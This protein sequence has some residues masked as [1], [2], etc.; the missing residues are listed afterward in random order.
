MNKISGKIIVKESGIGIPNLLIVF[1][2]YDPKSQPGDIITS[3][4][5]DANFWSGIKGDRIGSV[6]TDKTGSFTL[7]FEDDVFLEKNA[8]DSD[9]RPDL[10]LFVL[11]PEDTL[12]E[13]ADIPY[14][15]SPKKQ[16]L[17]YSHVMRANAGRTENYIIRLRTKQ[18][19]NAEIP[20]PAAPTPGVADSTNI[21]N[22]LEES[23]KLQNQIS[24][25]LASHARKKAK[26]VN[27][28]EKAAQ[29]AFQNFYPSAIPKTVRADTS[30]LAPGKNLR[31]AQR[32]LIQR[33]LNAWKKPASK[34]SIQFIL[35]KGEV[36][37][38]GLA[39]HDDGTV[40]G[41]VGADEVVG[42]VEDS[43]DGAEISAPESPF[44][45]CRNEIEADKKIDAIT[46]DKNGTTEV[47]DRTDGDGVDS[48]GLTAEKLTRDMVALHMDRA[49]SAETQVRFEKPQDPS[50]KD[51]SETVGKIEFGGGATDVT[52][53]HDFYNLQ[54]A[55]EHV[56]T[57]IF[58]GN[59][60]AAGRVLY[61]QW[62]Q[63]KNVA[64]GMGIA[65]DEDITDVETLD[66]LKALMSSV[67]ALN[68]QLDETVEIPP[69]IKKLLPTLTPEIW[70]Q[71]EPSDQ[72]TL[73]DFAA[74]AYLS[75][76][77]AEDVPGLD[78][79][80][81]PR[82]LEDEE[83]EKRIT[84]NRL[85]ALELL[86][87]ATRKKITKDKKPIGLQQ[88][89][90]ELN[91]RLKS[92]YRFDIFAPDSVNLGVLVTYRQEW[93]PGKFQ[94]G[95]LVSTIPLAP[96]EVRKYSKK[97]VTKRSRKE[98]EIENALNIRKGE[99][100]NT[101][102]IEGEIVRKAN[103]KTNFKASAEGSINFGVGSAQASTGLEIDQEK[104]SAQTKKDFREAVTKAAQE[105]KQENKLEIESSSA[106]EFEET[107]S[108][109]ISNPNDEIPVTYLFYELQRQ[110]QIS[111]KLH[112]LTPV[113]LVANHVPNP[114]DIDEDWLIAHDWILRRVILDDTFLPALDFLSQNVVGDE[115]SLEILHGNM[116][117]QAKIVEE[118]KEQV[119][120]KKRTHED[121][122]QALEEKLAS[123][124]TR[125]RRD[126]DEERIEAARMAAEA[127]REVVDRFT[128]ELNQLRSDLAAQV[129]AH[130]EATDKYTNALRDHLNR[131]TEIG[132]LRNHV[133]DNILYYMQAIWDHEPPDQRFFRLYNIEVPWFSKPKKILKGGGMK[134]VVDSG[135]GKVHFEMEPFAFVPDIPKEYRKL[136]EIADLDNLLGYKGNY[137]IFPLKEKNYLT[138]LMM[139]PY[140][141]KRMDKVIAKD[142]D[143]YGNFTIDDFDAYMRCV[144]EKS[145]EDFE[146][147][148][149]EFKQVL[150]Q[151]LSTA[152]RD[153]EL[154]VVPTD[155][156]YIEALKGKH[157]IMEDFKLIHR[158]LDVKKVQAEVRHAE[159][160]NV[161]LSAR[162]LKGELEDPDIEKKI[163]VEGDAQVEVG[164]GE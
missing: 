132:R 9:A 85:N 65:V 109:E 77:T 24:R 123:H 1:Y 134:A 143:E 67:E 14:A 32:N 125:V 131:Q 76:I 37:E 99:S 84:E 75:E 157:P 114:K 130:Q 140:I 100:S 158:A 89:L 2:D 56:W 155:S 43:M 103:I 145:P 95:D 129:S 40:E 19:E 98:K 10:L 74:E 83:R 78:T 117:Q 113:V 20:I 137:M 31:I 17:H 161:R 104:N 108:G 27:D 5:S 87:A 142:P 88:L 28:A 52:A 69:L 81:N 47:T 26:Q 46:E 57:E 68:A 23:F 62:V 55:F 22:V 120:H 36:E 13:P 164:G 3:Q 107:I 118:L 51:I 156:L 162:L 128:A 136:V 35:T 8:N 101:G 93:K 58:D 148:R 30:Y 21:T 45:L 42:R 54:I 94:V 4:Q 80:R 63:F 11:G 49:T 12:D 124:R 15:A 111:E 70:Q 105:Y 144:Y 149:A 112:K 29:T 39:I 146:A 71:L 91:G 64:S 73:V 110:Y 6:L 59:V 60:A 102:R 86:A 119:G 135:T 72:S 121:A 96:K 152:R 41:E 141:D 38:I 116:K 16:I 127:A 138:T 159:I 48:R 133:K 90:A 33:R 79:A 122:L 18:L 151:R 115:F 92:K 147:K 44:E 160:E 7:E 82:R 150:L 97:S 163:V 126:D 50:A 106:V 61:N 153:T 154:V 34:Q 66:D 25:K 53:Y 139:L